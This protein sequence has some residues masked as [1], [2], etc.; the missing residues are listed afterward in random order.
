LSCFSLRFSAFSAPLRHLL[1]FLLLFLTSFLPFLLPAAFAQDQPVLTIDE[2]CTAFAFAPDGRIAYAVRRIHSARRIQMQRDDL[3]ITSLD[4]K[5]KR[6][7]NGEKYLAGRVPVSYAIHSLGW[8]PD[9][10][11]LTVE[12]TVRQMIDAEGETREAL[13]TLLFD[14]AGKEIKIEGGDNSIAGASQA[15]WLGDGVTVGFLAEAVKP[16]L[17]FS[18][19]SVRPIA[20]RGSRLFEKSTFTAVAWDPKRNAAAAIERD[21]SL[22]GPPRLV[23][24]DLLKQTRR[25]LAEL[26]GYLG[27]LSVSP[28]GTKVAY[29][30]GPELLEIRNVNAPDQITR[31]RVLQGPFAWAPDESRILIKRGAARRASDLMWLRLP[32]KA[33]ADGPA[34]GQVEQVLHG[35]SYWDFEISPDG[36]H[37]AVTSPGKRIL[38]VYPLP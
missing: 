33:Q 7:I 4:G 5:K 24:L 12:M 2:D 25:V 15:A 38:N 27:S 29:F 19:N 13:I 20:G 18:M 21:E 17:L 32:A 23:W 36:R 22:S 8:S 28:S 11:R 31:V 10:T 3:W 30:S 37:L 26:D 34:S 1:T 14:D 9:G 35:L 16:R 6:L